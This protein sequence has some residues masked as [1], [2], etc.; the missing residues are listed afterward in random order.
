MKKLLLLLIL[1][2]GLIGISSGG[3]IDTNIIKL[4]EMSACADCRLK[5]ANLGGADL[6]G[7]HLTRANLNEAKLTTTNKTTA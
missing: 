5:R 4:K 3:E 1:S 7:Q 2:L 6:T